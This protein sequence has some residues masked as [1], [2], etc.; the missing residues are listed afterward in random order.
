MVLASCHTKETA[1]STEVGPAHVE[2][3]QSQPTK[4]SNYLALIPDVKLPYRFAFDGINMTGDT[5]RL[6]IAKLDNRKDEGKYYEPDPDASYAQLPGAYQG[7]IAFALFKFKVNTELTAVAYTFQKTNPNIIYYPFVELLIFNN[8]G[9]IKGRQVIASG[10]LDAEHTERTVFTISTPDQI[11]T[12]HTVNEY[13]DSTRTGAPLNA[14]QDKVLYH[15]QSD[16]KI[17][18]TKKDNLSIMM[19]KLAR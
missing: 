4:F 9:N 8:Q 5:T 14:L 10:M 19:E 3:Q 15:I 13:A 6:D 17:V 18:E 11:N 1:K 2:T 16:G 12:M 7:G